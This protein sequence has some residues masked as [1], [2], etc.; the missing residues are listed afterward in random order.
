[1]RVELAVIGEIRNISI[2]KKY[3]RRTEV[4][5]RDIEIFLIKKMK[6]NE[7]L[8][9]ETTNIHIAI[10]KS[11]WQIKLQKNPNLEFKD[12]DTNSNMSF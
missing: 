3:T 2:T 5:D 9:I 7:D 10:A 6:K 12:M 1:M 4:V 8:L 11:L